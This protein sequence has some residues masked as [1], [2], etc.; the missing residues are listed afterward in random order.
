L[1]FAAAQRQL[2]LGDHLSLKYTSM[3]RECFQV[4]LA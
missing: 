4:I 2:P 1:V 3:S